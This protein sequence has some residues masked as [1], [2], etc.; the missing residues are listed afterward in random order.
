MPRRLIR[1]LQPDAADTHVR[2][3]FPRKR[4]PLSVSAGVSPVGRLH[5]W[6]DLGVRA[7]LNL[8]RERR[9]HVLGLS[10]PHERQRN[11]E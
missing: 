11:G 5:L 2:G 7:D 6:R 9:T 4:P 3:A 8:S 10:W 1:C